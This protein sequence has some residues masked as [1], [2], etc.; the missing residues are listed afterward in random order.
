MNPE[1]NHP[2]FPTRPD[3]IRDIL[4]EWQLKDTWL[5]LEAVYNSGKVKAIGVSN[6]SQ[7]K[8]EEEIL[9]FANVVPAVNQLEIHP[10]LPQHNLTTWLKSRDIVVQCYSPLGS[11]N[12]PL[13]K[14]E[15]VVEIAEKHKVTPAAVLIGWSGKL[16]QVAGG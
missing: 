4:T 8:L 1:G 6:C 16:K 13:L 9:P 3:G 5:Q 15:V 10:Y 2:F 12:S 14:D 11:S 7:L